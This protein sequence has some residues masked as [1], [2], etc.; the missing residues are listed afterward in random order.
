MP[1]SDT[2]NTPAPEARATPGGSVPDGTLVSELRRCVLGVAAPGVGEPSP[3]RAEFSLPV[4][5]PSTDLEP[6][7]ASEVR[8]R[9][10]PLPLAEALLSVVAVLSCAM[11]GFV[12]SPASLR[13]VN[14]P[15]ELM[16]T[17]RAELRMRWD[18][19]CSSVLRAAARAAGMAGSAP[20]ASARRFDSARMR[21]WRS[22]SASAAVLP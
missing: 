22:A 10:G 11:C 1:A 12:Y 19:G 7:V 3:L 17:L 6:A 20:F 14:V 4:L 13:V 9:A 8:E 16:P 2:V 18:S 15:D 5:L 21:L